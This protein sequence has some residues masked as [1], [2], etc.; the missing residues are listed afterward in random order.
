MRLL[1]KVKSGMI[2]LL[3]NK[4][5]KTYIANCVDGAGSKINVITSAKNLNL[6]IENIELIKSGLRVESINLMS[7]CIIIVTKN[8]FDIQ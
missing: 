8:H 5:M 1:K 4:H 3:N 7:D 6:G 2:I